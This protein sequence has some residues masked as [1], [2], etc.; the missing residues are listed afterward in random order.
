VSSS[1]LGEAIAAH[2]GT[3]QWRS[4]RMLSARVRSGGFAL[5]SHF[6]SAPVADYEIAVSADEPRAV[7]SPYPKPGRR[8]IFESR[9]VRIESDDGSTVS[10]R[11]D[12]RSAFGGLSGLRRNVRWDH[13]DLLY[14]AGYA[15]WNYLNLPFLLARDD[16]QVRD[17][18]TWKEDDEEWRR[19]EAS[20]PTGLPTHSR[21]QA[22]YFDQRG[23][24]RRHDYTAEPFGSWAKAA[25]YSDQHREFEG[26]V[27]PTR[28]RVFPR[29]RDGR[30]RGRPI[31]VWIDLSDVRVSRG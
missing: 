7:F 8:G 5:A 19:L 28:R 10:E 30:A 27:L 9:R 20:F 12:P 2:G 22:F 21:E 13:L 17:G 11:Q 25:H 14:F 18:G 4:T 1:L 6:Q 15:M 26:L 23:L 3:E 31:L 16:V 29:R 24:L